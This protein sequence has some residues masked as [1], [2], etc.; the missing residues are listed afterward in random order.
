[1]IAGSAGGRDTG[2]VTA[3]LI[4]TGAPGAGKSS[5]LEALAT[6]LELEGVAFGAIESE[7]LAWGSPTLS[8]ADWTAQ[9]R[10][11]LALQREAGR[12]LF[13]IAATAETEGELRSVIDAA[14]ANEALVACLAAPA[15]LLAE[16][17]AAREP[18][19]WPGKPAL[20]SRAREL[21]GAIPGLDGVDL[22]LDTAWLGPTQVAAQLLDALARRGMLTGGRPSSAR[23]AADEHPR[24]EV[25]AEHRADLGAEQGL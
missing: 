21:S 4:I 3:A 14:G 24:A 10:A 7:Q 25:R 13:L 15:A 23:H 18:D 17:L 8:A 20:I 2:C 19:D 9:L 11:V 6:L 16:R 1:M 12:T 22:V 5:A